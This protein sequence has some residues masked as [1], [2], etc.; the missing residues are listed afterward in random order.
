[1]SRLFLGLALALLLS[2]ASFA[3]EPKR[4]VL[5]IIS[6]DL[7]NMLGCYGDPRA[8]TPNLDSLAARGE[9]V[10]ERCAK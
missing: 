6:D 2:P 8:K 9:W 4:N 10:L 7:N 5:F 3:A 1:M